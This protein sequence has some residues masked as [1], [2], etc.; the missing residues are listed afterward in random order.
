[1]KD[2]PF[3]YVPYP[4]VVSQMK[5]LAPRIRGLI[6]KI[7]IEQYDLQRFIGI[8]N[9]SASFIEELKAAD[10]LTLAY[11]IVVAA[12]ASRDPKFVGCGVWKKLSEIY[13]HMLLPAMTVTIELN[14]VAGNP[15]GE[16]VTDMLKIVTQAR[17]S[18][19]RYLE[20]RYD[21]QVGFSPLVSGTFLRKHA[22]N[23]PTY[24]IA[25]NRLISNA[26]VAVD[27]VLDEMAAG[28]L[29]TWPEQEKMPAQR[30]E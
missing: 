15:P 24:R 21:E 11:C 18:A 27:S 2:H 6:D 28:E 25:L 20:T 14:R 30:T 26:L 3:L 8:T 9:Y 13:Q 1:V 29:M 17:Q 22:I 7:G 10:A 23:H 16:P 12:I 5:A 19:S 4:K